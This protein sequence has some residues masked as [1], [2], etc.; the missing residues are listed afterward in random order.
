MN[1]R[2]LKPFVMPAL[3]G[4]L[5]LVLLLSMYFA[6]EIVSNFKDK[7]NYEYVDGEITEDN[8]SEIPVV[9][10]SAKITRPYLDSSVTISKTFYDYEADASEQEKSIIFYEDTYIQN[11]GV[12][13]TSQNVFDIISVLDGTVI[14]VEENDILGT[15]VEIRHSN[16]LI[17]VY[18]SLSDVIVKKDDAVIQGQII[19]KSGLSN[20]NKD[21][22]NHLHFELYYKGKIVNPEE[23]YNRFVD[24]L[25]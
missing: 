23:F 1:S 7:G 10:T 17:S 9:S 22:G 14:S 4:G 3:Y 15:T 19:A 24:E 11:S 2:R 25:Q 5:V 6:K 16:D 12:D 8:N 20:I 13:Y 18:Q 21:L